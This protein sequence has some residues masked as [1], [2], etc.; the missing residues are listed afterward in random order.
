MATG[1][2]WLLSFNAAEFQHFH[3]EAGHGLRA[4]LFALGNPELVDAQE[5][6]GEV[7]SCVFLFLI[8]EEL[9]AVATLPAIFQE[10]MQAFPDE[11]LNFLG[12][13]FR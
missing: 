11:L 12:A 4:F 1:S 7:D 9:V 3:E 6:I 5:G 13:I 10:D 8:L 2:L